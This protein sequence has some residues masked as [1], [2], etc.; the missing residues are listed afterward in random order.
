MNTIACM[1]LRRKFEL[2]TSWMRE[3]NFFVSAASNVLV[4]QLNASFLPPYALRASAT[5]DK[6]VLRGLWTGIS[7]RPL[8]TEPQDS[9]IARYVDLYDASLPYSHTHLL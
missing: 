8:A 4:F 3:S 5:T 7:L 6:G 1:T 2:A 9:I